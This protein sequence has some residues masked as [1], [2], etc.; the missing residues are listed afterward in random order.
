[1]KKI[2]YYV[3]LLCFPLLLNAADPISI[4]QYPL[5][6]RPAIVKSAE[7]FNI[8]CKAANSTT[9]WEVS[10]STEYNS[11]DLNISSRYDAEQNLWVL[12]ATI[13]PETPFELY[14]L[15][16]NANGLSDDVVHAVKVIKEFKEPYYFVHLPDLHLPSVSWIGF[17]DDNNTIPEFNRI[18]NE[19]EIINPEF[20]L[21]TGDIV[22]NGQQEDQ[23]QIVQDL[24]NTVKV[25]LFL[26]GGNHDLWYDGHAN[27]TKYIN[28]VM[29]YSFN[30]GAH[31]FAG[32]E[33]YDIPTV[34]FTAAQMKWLQKE[35]E[36]S[37]NRGDKMRSLFYHYDE[38]RQI[39]SDFV[40]DFQVD[41]LLYGHTHINGTHY[42]GARNALNLNTSFTMNDNGVYRLIKV[43]ENQVQEFP[44]INYKKMN[45]IYTPTNDGSNPIVRAIIKND[46]PVSFENGQV[47]FLVTKD[48]AGYNVTGGEVEQIIPTPGYDVYYVKVNIKSSSI[49]KV[50]IQSNSLPGN[51]PPGIV[52]ASPEKYLTVLAGI[53]TSYS[54]TATDAN[55]DALVFEW[56]LD[57]LQIPGAQNRSYNFTPPQNFTGLTELLVKVSDGQ[58]HDT[59]K[60]IIEVDEFTDKPKLITP[61]INFFPQNENMEL[62]WIEPFPMDA[63]FEYGLVPGDFTGRINEFENQK[64][65]FTPASEGM[66]LGKYYCRITDGTVSSDQFTITIESGIAAN[67][68]T[69]IGNIT[70]LSPAFSWERVPGVPY[71]MVICSDR[72][73]II[74]QD[75][76]T[77][78]FAIEGANPIW[79]VL[80]SE[81]SVP[82]GM[83][84][85]SNTYTSTPSP[86]VPGQT[87]WWI[88][89]NC[90]GNSPELVSPVQSG[91]SQFTVDL[92]L[93]DMD[94]PFLLAPENNVTLEG[95]NIL[96][97]WQAARNA[98]S[99]NFYP[100]KMENESGIETAR[101][102]WENIIS[103]T[104]TE[105]VLSADSYLIDGN[106]RWRVASVAANGVE[107]PSES[108]DFQFKAPSAT[109]SLYT[110][111]NKNTPDNTGDDVSLPRVSINYTALDGVSSS[112]PLSTDLHGT[113]VDYKIGA[114][115]FIFTVEK[116]QYDVIVDTLTF[117]V[118]N[119]LRIDYRLSPSKSTV[120][121]KVQ[122]GD[123]NGVADAAIICEHSLHSDIKKTTK[124]D[125]FGNFSIS[126]IPGPY[127]IYAEK[128]GFKNNSPLSFSV[129]SGETLAMDTP[130]SLV[131]N[132]NEIFGTVFNSSQ[133]PVYGVKVVLSKAD[134]KFERQTDTNGLYSFYVEDGTWVLFAEKSGFVSPAETSVSVTGGEQLEISPPIVLQLN[135]G[136]LQGKVSDG[137]RVLPN[138]EVTVTPAAGNT[139]KTTTDEYGQFSLS[140]SAGTFEIS[141][142]K[143]NYTFAHPVQVA[144]TA[145]KTIS[146]I[147][148]EL[149]PAQSSIEGKVTTDGYTPLSDVNV[150]NESNSA[151]T[152]DGGFYS[153]GVNYGTLTIAAFKEGFT[154]SGP[155]SVT[156]A[157]GQ[158]IS[159]VNFILTPNASV[160]K[161]RIISEKG[162][163]N[164]AIIE[165]E[166]ETHYSTKSDENGNYVINV[167]AGEWTI[168][169]S[170]PG[171]INASKEN[172]WVG[173]GQ[174]TSEINFSLLPNSA[175]LQGIVKQQGDGVALRDV[176]INL[177][178]HNLSTKTN[179]DG[180]FSFLVE[181]DTY[182]L[183]FAKSGYNPKS[184]SSG[185]LANNEVKSLNVSLESLKS[186][187]EGKIIDTKNTP[188]QNANISATGIETFAA[189]SKTDGRFRLDVK[190]GTYTI[191]VQKTGYKDLLL[192]GPLI[193]SANEK[194][195]LDIS[196]MVLALG[197]INGKTIDHTTK[198]SIA[199]VNLKAVGDDGFVAISK[200]QSNGEFK[201][202]DESANYLLV[203]GQFSLVASKTGY[204]TKEI[205]NI[206]VRDN[207]SVIVEIGLEKNVGALSGV[208]SSI[209]G[210]IEN[211]TITALNPGTSKTFSTLT[212]S[213]GQYKLSN[214][215][216]GNYKVSVAKFGHTSP[217]PQTVS[218]NSVVDF[219]LMKNTGRM[220]GVV[221]DN[222][223]G[224]AIAGVELKADDSFGNNGTVITNS[225]GFYDL[226]GL[227]Q[228]NPYNLTVTKSG[229]VAQHAGPITLIT[230][231]NLDFELERLYGNISGFVKNIS[232]TPM[233]D[234]KV[235]LKSGAFVQTETTDSQG[236]FLFL[237]LPA[238]QYTIEVAL[239]GYSS[240]P[241]QQIT[242]LWLGNTVTDVNFVMS[243]AKV[244]EIKILGP[245]NISNNSIQKYG[246]SAYTIDGREASV[247]PAWEIDFQPAV[248]NLGNNG[249]LDPQND[250]VGT[251]TLELKDRLTNESASKKLSIYQPLAPGHSQIQMEDKR[252]VQLLLQDSSIVQNV[253]VQLRRPQFADVRRNNRSFKVVG[254]VYQFSPSNFSLLKPAQ[255]ILPIDGQ[256]SGKNLRVGYWDTQWLE[257]KVLPDV[258]KVGSSIQI[259]ID[260]L[261]TFALL[262]NAEP[263]NI[264]N[265]KVLPNPF[266]PHTGP[267]DISFSVSSDQTPT[268]EVSLKIYNMVGDLVK[269]LLPSTLL[270]RGENSVPWDGVTDFGRM[271]KNGRYLLH[272]EVSD[273]SGTKDNLVPFV[274]I[275]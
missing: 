177:V 185:P 181:P 67:M 145:G 66:G 272:L 100:F 232:N 167:D 189:T 134:L 225:A 166:G 251:F 82:Y 45:I 224:L 61:V 111:D 50:I 154:S 113:R 171:F 236:H 142:A 216:N 174:T 68:I 139:F 186:Y 26:T 255:L 116:E 204:I 249:L 244:A 270:P 43:A 24:F 187:F 170:K 197:G 198:A 195:N 243:E 157:A 148:L 58:Y 190:P 59:F 135:A 229:Y 256:E 10:I 210:P 99:F 136:I 54:V 55:G 146:G 18:V 119:S 253:S 239:L 242:S 34:T 76:E 9:G 237:K 200:S 262:A 8:L 152:S 23:Y 182:T 20:V 265:I 62:A 196:P 92:P 39:T 261:G 52:N 7:A 203:P 80:T 2:K 271:A 178:E 158:K 226:P 168:R 273:I 47:K 102:I 28:P 147:E 78:D 208:V 140:L 274:L 143:E 259:Q 71:Y 150:F 85:P 218:V 12:T 227:P 132:R 221:K 11:I 63:R 127:Q 188:I 129:E 241:L 214:L 260:R 212:K 217:A 238:Q 107:L 103:T 83:P 153:L 121:G 33:M 106:Y 86:L 60:W 6:S 149:L 123:N 46:N 235:S 65:S 179:S 3:L 19:L 124:S 183:L 175:M 79:A 165:A 180:T 27:W 88:V 233:A 74:L 4:V 205:N 120:T 35:L 213:G 201:F 246:F 194:V 72:E 98:A 228:T 250:F 69:P 73:I 258:N 112:L 211:A 128:E 269:T 222:E 15:Q 84:D 21:Q 30:Y 141:A 266:S 231:T 248:E 176:H 267:A 264:S 13:P 32:M 48:A 56:F 130:I 161:G 151:Q 118:G 22:D 36:L 40:D 215:P 193:A 17:Y 220:S 108:R 159:D 207:S 110:F 96:F 245:D 87:Y 49:Q 234:V 97:K 252:G 240:D 122:N 257:W 131:K 109:V 191:A 95:E 230:D 164:D 138:V 75:P 90:Y 114:G 38:S 126:L 156:V 275:K 29:D 199:T 117:E 77:G 125:A 268:P 115:T 93:P 192:P 91:F 89:L 105:Y 163:I 172:V 41:L 209:S 37:Q 254:D 104:D 162:A 247:D 202:V 16:V 53:A 57:G 94:A 14:N 44:L 70:D 160:I 219:F 31:F 101:A 206:T 263:L 5:A 81:N 25:P 155:E 133:Q 173:I 64:V 1:M 184:V 137:F 51:I 169:V 144:V 42:L 223:S